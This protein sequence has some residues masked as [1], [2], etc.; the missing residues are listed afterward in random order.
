MSWAR[1]KIRFRTLHFAVLASASAA[2][3]L[4][5]LPPQMLETQREQYFDLLT[6]FA[7]PLQSDRIVVIDIDRAALAAKPSQSWQRSDTARL[8]R[9]IADAKPAVMAFDLV[10]SDK[11]DPEDATNIALASAISAAPSV[12][13]FLISDGTP[14]PPEPRPNLAYSKGI[15][16]PSLW[17][18]DG[19]E[20]SCDLFEK[21]AV[22]S[23]AS[24]LVGDED[25]RV[26]RVQAYSIYQN[27]AYPALA[28][29][30]V[31]LSMALPVTAVLTASPLALKI[32]SHTINLAE[33][34]SIRFSAGNQNAVN[35]RTIS[36]AKVM[37]DDFRPEAFA[38]KIV[39]I[40]SSLPNLGG[41]RSTASMPL[42]PSVQIHA[43]IANNILTG[44]IPTR[45]PGFIRLEALYVLVAGLCLSV[46]ASR[47]RPRGIALFGIGTILF[48]LCLT[49]VIFA[50]TGYLLDGISVTLVLV[51]L[52]AFTIFMQFSHVRRIES[53]ARQRFGQYL[54][55]SI[56]SRYLDNPDMVRM[57]GE[58][59]Q[60]TALFTDI[61][62]FSALAQKVGPREM[63]RMLDIYFAEVTRLVAESGGM[64]DKIVGDAV[65]AFFN[66]PEDLANHVDRAVE[67]AEKIMLLTEELRQRPDF[68]DGG[69]GRTRIGIETGTVVFGEVGSGGKL[70]FTAHGHAINLASRLQEA[71]KFLG[72]SICVGPAAAAQTKR[73]LKNLG[74]HDIRSAGK[75]EL[76]TL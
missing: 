31:R 13:G 20:K 32:N 56:V 14:A 73:T 67:C 36:A 8:V 37:E 66:A 76:F 71:N 51:F 4:F 38:G 72:T 7:A 17:F 15:R 47:Q 6:Q 63:I 45:Y 16:M 5:W 1:L 9:K 70:D 53:V 12:M 19:S 41:L 48:S 52:L 49:T 18:I 64:V 24:F 68:A 10:F 21:S 22:S 58:E 74:Q 54:P 35:A 57:E 42:E 3:I 23:A 75:I 27:Y 59:R 25:A 46:S 60:V 26:R 50:T 61:E 29:E 40:G 43:D 34:G 69:F 28:T 65:H 44:F 30:A 55:K 11:C 33:E 39:F 62:S 2:L